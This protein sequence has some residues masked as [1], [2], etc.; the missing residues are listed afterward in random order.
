MTSTGNASR[1]STPDL[2]RPSARVAFVLGS[3]LVGFVIAFNLLDHQIDSQVFDYGKRPTA[4]PALNIWFDSNAPLVYLAMTNTQTRMQMTNRHPLFPYIGVLPVKAMRR[5]GIPEPLGVCL[6]LAFGVGLMSGLF[7]L[8]LTLTLE[9]AAL[10]GLGAAVL[11]CVG[12]VCVLVGTLRALFVGKRNHS[13]G[14]RRGGV[15][16]P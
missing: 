6:V 12:F 5:L 11:S 16:Q 1:A 9:N 14:D 10:M 13:V 15:L 3:F 4:Q 7:A 8:T 2:K